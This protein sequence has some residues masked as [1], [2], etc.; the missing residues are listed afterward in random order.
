MSKERVS[1]QAT[2]TMSVGTPRTSSVGE[3]A[4]PAGSTSKGA[5]MHDRIA[6]L[7]YRFY[8]Q[9]GRQEGRALEDWLNAELQLIGVVG[10]S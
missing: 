10:Q 4:G 5:L 3:K 8:E 9:R 2:P 1:R 6:Q 7:A